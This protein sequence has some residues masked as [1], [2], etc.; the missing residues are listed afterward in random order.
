MPDRAS[1]A[2]TAD[3]SMGTKQDRPN[4]RRDDANAITVHTPGVGPDASEPLAKDPAKKRKPSEIL[5]YRDWCKSCGICIAFCPT[6]V[7]ET[8][9]GGAPVIAHPEK[10][11][12]CE[13]CEL[14]CP[15]FAITLHRPEDD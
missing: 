8:G 2:S 5:I 15:D 3:E 12:S 6:K 4:S 11:I 9:D 1:Q 14:L 10:C 13:L 7:F